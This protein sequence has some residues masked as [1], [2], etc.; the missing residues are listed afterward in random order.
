MYIKALRESG[1]VINTAIVRA[2]AEGIVKAEDS[3]LLKCNGGHIECTKH[4]AVNML[5]RLG[6]VKRKANSKAKVSVEDFEAAKLQ[7]IFDISA[8]REME[9]IPNQLVLN[10]DHTGINYIPVS[11]WT[12]AKEGT[13]RIEIGG[14]G[15]KRQ[16]TLVLAGSLSGNILPFQVIYTGKTPKCL[17]SLEFPADWDLAFTPNNWANEGTTERYINIFCVLTSQERG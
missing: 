14:L 15:D 6:Y 11:S 16:L 2:A 17:P 9:G 12:M 3:N 13:K 7:F 5:G 4:W 1:A 10:W 8:I